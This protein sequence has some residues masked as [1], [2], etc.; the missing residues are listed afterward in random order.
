M[1]KEF[2]GC[3]ESK[4][5]EELGFDEECLGHYKQGGLIHILHYGICGS[6]KS[7]SFNTLAPLYQQAFKFFRDKYKMYGQ[8]TIAEFE[9]INESF[10]YEI[11][12]NDKS[13]DTWRGGYKTYEEAEKECLNKLIELCT[14]N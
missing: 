10:E 4:Q 11:K 13:I 8:I 12:T 5:L 3:K 6:K 14:K 1:E 9:H 2:I 7:D